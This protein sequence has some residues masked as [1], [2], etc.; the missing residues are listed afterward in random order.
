MKQ[1]QFDVVY[2]FYNL[3]T[4][5]ELR[6]SIRSVVKNFSALRHIWVIGDKPE[7][8]NALLRHLPYDHVAH[9]PSN[10]Y[11]KNRNIC[12]KMDLAARNERVTE[13][14]IYLADDYFILKPWSGEDF[15]TKVII[16]EDMDQINDELREMGDRSNE[17]LNEWKRALWWTY[18]RIKAEGYSGLNY[19]THTPKLINKKRLIQTFTKFGIRHGMLIWHTAYFNMHWKIE[20]VILSEESGIKASFYASHDREEIESRLRRAI[21]ANCNDDGRNAEFMDAIRER[22]PEKT[23]YED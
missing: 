12:E 13:N 5:D 22:F 3:N 10:V 11:S 9:L 4:D 20:R 2:P 16:R 1:L 23:R 6:Y 18:D 17:S 8:A 15:L 21:F 7:W 14:F 19:E